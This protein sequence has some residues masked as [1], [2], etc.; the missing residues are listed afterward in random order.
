MT[1]SQTTAP[2]ETGRMPTQKLAVVSLLS[3]MRMGW[4][5]PNG[6]HVLLQSPKKYAAKV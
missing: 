5:D 6:G 3:K 4:E 1:Q 2:Q